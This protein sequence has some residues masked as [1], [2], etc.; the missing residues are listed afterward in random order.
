MM[1]D[2]AIPQKFRKSS[3]IIF[4]TE[5]YFPKSIRKNKILK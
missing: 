4:P 5:F 1:E 3:K 2:A